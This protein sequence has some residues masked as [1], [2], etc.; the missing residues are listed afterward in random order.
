MNAQ[1]PTGD[2]LQHLART[3]REQAVSI[4]LPAHPRGQEKRQD[5]LRF[6]NLVDEAQ[7]H[8]EARG[9]RDTETL[10]KPLRDL[11]GETPSWADNGAPGL[12]FYL[13]AGEDR[14][15]GIWA[16]SHEPDAFAVVDTRYHVLPIV[17]TVSGE[18]VF[19]ILA[20]GQDEIR[21]LRA[22]PRHVERVELPEAPDD[23]GDILGL[24]MQDDQLQW[25]TE[26]S[27]ATGEPERKAMFHGQG[28]ATDE[29]DRKKKLMEYIQR[30]ED[31][32]TRR[33]KGDQARLLI[34]A[35][36]PLNGLY[37]QANQYHGLDE[38]T[39]KGHPERTPDKELLQRA[40]D[41]LG[42]LAAPKRQE[43]IERFGNADAR[44]QTVTSLDEALQ[45]TRRAQAGAIFLRDG[46]HRWG[47]YDAAEGTV[48]QHPERQPGDI[49]LLNRLAVHGLEHGAQVYLVSAEEMPS[50]DPV[51]ATLR[52]PTG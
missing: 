18:E 46:E 39:L 21:F 24:Y 37:R 16:L 34:A 19:Y 2:D 48:T 1:L 42:D 4:L 29:R 12:A 43:A 8:L 27:P 52:F 6:R 3:E 17:R 22:T 40:M 51:A 47:G 33:L 41:L 26:T 13:A 30:V 7:S 23:F 10:V 44:G 36:E 32:V 45:A 38:R 11:Q 25:H 14:D 49:D 20:L 5:P 50:A 28:V 35:T 15:P 9:I 31:A